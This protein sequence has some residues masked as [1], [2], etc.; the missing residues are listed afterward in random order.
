MTQCKD[1][2]TEPILRFIYEVN[3]GRAWG[4][5]FDVGQ[6]AFPANTPDK[7]Y[8]A[9]MRTLFK[10][11]Y[12]TGCDCGCRGDYVVTMK[13]CELLGLPSHGMHDYS[14]LPVG[15]QKANLNPA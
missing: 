1:I 12:L 15:A 9:K 6:K 2:P 3:K 13:G 8:W 11:G 4:M 7:L 5:S 14:G 10:N